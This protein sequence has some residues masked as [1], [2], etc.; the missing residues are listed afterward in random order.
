MTSSS[1]VNSLP[2]QGKGQARPR[3][4]W[5]K[6]RKAIEFYEKEHL[7][8]LPASWGRKNPSVKW[9]EFQGRAPTLEEKAQ[10][11]HEGKP[12]NIGVLCGGASGGLILLCFNDVSGAPEFFGEEW[13][14]SLLKST[15]VTQSVRGCHVWLRSDSPIQG[16]MIGKGENESWLE[17][18]SGGMFAVAPPS[19]HP[20]GDLY[21]AV[22]VDRIYQVKD[23]AGFIDKRLA[24]L[25]L[26]VQGSREATTGGRPE[27]SDEFNTLAIEKLLESCA[28]I[29]YCRDNAATLSEPWWWSMVH[30]LAVFGEPGR[31]EIHELS[32]SYPKYTE[33]ETEQKVVE[34]LKAGDKEIGPHTCAFI[35]QALHFGCPAD[36][37]AKTLGV[38][39]PAGLASKLATAEQ[40]EGNYITETKDGK[41]KLNLA[42][43]TLD[44]LTEFS[45]ATMQDTD[46][47]LVYRDEF[48]R[49]EGEPF[50]KAECQRRVGVKDVLTLNKANEILG[51]IQ[52]T[53]YCDRNIFNREK[54]VIN[55]E[56]GLLDVR[57][58]VLKPHTPKFLSTIRIPVTYDSQADCP[59]ITQFFREVL[60]PEDIPVME[61]L[62]GYC[63]IPDYSIQKGFLF[64]G[65]GANG[66]STLLSLLKAFI[67]RDNCSNVPWHALELDK[68]ALSAL[69][70]KL[71]NLFADIPSRGLNLTSSFKMLTGGDDIGT[72][73]KFRNRYSFV[74]FARLVFSAN[75]PPRVYDEDS[76]AFWRRW[77]I[78][79]FPNEFT[80]EKDDK[81]ILAKLTTKKELSGLLNLALEGMRRLL[82]QG[83]Y[84]YSKTV[85]GTTEIYLRAA[86]PVY[87]FVQDRC[88]Q[89]PDAYVSKE[90]L[91]AAFTEYCQA[92]HLPVKKPNSF[93]RALQNQSHV[94]VSSI[95]PQVGEERITAWRGISLISSGG[96]DLVF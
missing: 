24:E 27:R 81:E 55:L 40:V 63:L 46:E 12:T 77:A 26:R 13:W 25:G 9:E 73:K 78:I 62:F 80:G 45:F 85:E 43:L 34:A 67:G 96:I 14:A 65:E 39:S 48:W 36:C 68:F 87:A 60:W 90:E 76:F 72:D 18:R 92:C 31:K 50:I 57:T 42:K 1:K 44:L 88:K 6:L 37:L 82:D 64:L 79:D 69:D 41:F 74:N 19:L 54:W 84:S 61:E 66:K 89:D 29:Q 56:N 51:H 30:I 2:G 86:D 58:K 10:W 35:D 23:L 70:G 16:Q 5:P 15:F 75:K 22:G 11:F 59:R 20:S 32:Q 71:V 94:K 93:A 38:R 83:R 47:I 7:C 52:R 33:V 4:S 3:F 91:Y 8:Y 95:R 17:I 28:F 53:T 49:Y 21:Q